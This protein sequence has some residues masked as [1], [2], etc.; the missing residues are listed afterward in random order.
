M[1]AGHGFLIQWPKLLEIGFLNP[2]TVLSIAFR[3]FLSSSSPR[4]VAFCNLLQTALKDPLREYSLN[5]SLKRFSRIRS[6]RAFDVTG[7]KAGRLSF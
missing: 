3:V 1:L 4:S 2:S 6:L 7:R 5:F